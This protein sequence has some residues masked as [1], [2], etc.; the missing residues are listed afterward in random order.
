VFSY[1]ANIV[2]L[3]YT[4]S[5]TEPPV[6]LKTFK[7][8]SKY[9]QTSRERA[10]HGGWVILQERSLEDLRDYLKHQQL[11]ENIN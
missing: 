11:N 9:C 1:A 7:T 4:E 10:G 3:F 5:V 6:L 8:I 2:A